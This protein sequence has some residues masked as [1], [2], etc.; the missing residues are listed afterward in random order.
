MDVPPLT[1]GCHRGHANLVG[2][3]A[4]AARLDANTTRLREVKAL[5]D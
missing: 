2:E 4:A 1:S 3:E 5:H